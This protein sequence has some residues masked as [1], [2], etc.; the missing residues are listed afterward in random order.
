MN[1]SQAGQESSRSDEPKNVL[2]RYNIARVQVL[3]RVWVARRALG[4]THVS[5]RTLGEANKPG[6]GALVFTQPR[7]CT[8]RVR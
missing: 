4:Y 1:T 2:K 7:H 6:A 5:E 8:V 3:H